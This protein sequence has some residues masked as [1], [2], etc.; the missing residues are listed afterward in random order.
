MDNPNA[1]LS[2][3]EVDHSEILGLNNKHAANRVYVA[4]TPVYAKLLEF[5]VVRLQGDPK[6]FDQLL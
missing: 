5:G 1:P 3:L 6:G 4:F 2:E